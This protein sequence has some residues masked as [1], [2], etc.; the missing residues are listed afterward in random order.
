MEC[1]GPVRAPRRFRLTLVGMWMRALVAVCLLGAC[2]DERIDA[3][4]WALG[5]PALSAEQQVDTPV[6]GLRPDMDY[7]TATAAWNGTHWLVVWS[8]WQKPLQGVRVAA[9]GTIVDPVPF[10]IASNY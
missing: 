8:G 6:T 3:H 7:G 10:T 9:D 2:G 4:R 1:E 5:G